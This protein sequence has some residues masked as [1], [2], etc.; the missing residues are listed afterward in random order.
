MV[1]KN[2]GKRISQMILDSLAKLNECEYETPKN[3]RKLAKEAADILG[4]A[5]GVSII[6][7]V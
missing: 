4:Y 6:K 2:F 3:V 7:G 1:D 5:Y